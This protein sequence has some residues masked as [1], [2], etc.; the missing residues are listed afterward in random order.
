MRIWKVIGVVAK[1]V[2]KRAGLD[3]ILKIPDIKIWLFELKGQV[4]VE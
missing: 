2:A 3:G 4:K 1:S